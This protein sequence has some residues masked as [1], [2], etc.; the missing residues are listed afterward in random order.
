MGLSIG[1]GHVICALA[2]R[3]SSTTSGNNN[4]AVKSEVVTVIED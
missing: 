2:E 4:H 3:L 1:I